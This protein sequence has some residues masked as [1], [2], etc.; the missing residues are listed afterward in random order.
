MTK[1]PLAGVKVLK[2]GQ[3]YA[4]PLAGMIL[5]QRT[6]PGSDMQVVGLPI[7]F[8]RQRPRPQGD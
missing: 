2:I 1:P 4:G 5:W 3:A 8:G 7:T 6:L